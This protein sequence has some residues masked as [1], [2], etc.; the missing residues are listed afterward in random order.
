MGAFAADAGAL[1]DAAELLGTLLYVDPA[2][3]SGAD[4]L[5]WA[6]G[7]DAAGAWPF[8][9]EEAA[10]ALEA[11]AADLAQRDPAE[12]HRA[13]ARLF[14]GPAKLPAPPWGSVYTDPEGVIFGNLT[15]DVRQWMREAGVTLRLPERQPEDHLGL[16]LLMLAWSLRADVDE[17]AARRLVEELMLPWAPRFLELLAERADDAFYGPLACLARVT[18]GDW[19]ARYGLVPPSLRLYR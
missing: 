7:A 4:A 6:A 8:G 14:V 16:M 2:A 18:L 9:G 1:A 3:A 12:R 5:A 11:L 17:R 15:L 19:Q 10:R 13:F